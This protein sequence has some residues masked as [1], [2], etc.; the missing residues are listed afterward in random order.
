MDISGKTIVCGLIGDPVEHS[1][2]PA[3]QNAAFRK[4]GLDYAYVPFRVKSE[5]VGRAIAGMRALNI[6]GLN[7]TMPHKVAVIPFLDR[8]DDL[9]TKIG[10]V[11]TIAN[12]A[13][14]LTGYNTDASGFLQS[15]IENG[16][17]PKGKRVLV[18][19]AGG[20]ARAVTFALMDRQASLMI[21]NRTLD[22]AQ[23][24][25]RQLSL[26]FY[27]EVESGLLS[28]QTL[29]GAVGRAEMVVNTTSVGM[30]AMAGESPV[31]SQLLRPGLL[32]YDIV[33][34]P[35]RTRFLREAEAAGCMTISGT[36]MLAWQGAFAFERWTGKTAPVDL[37][38]AEIVGH[39]ERPE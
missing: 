19:G 35:V 37:M 9:A 27:G 22:R 29:A 33:Y 23:E 18:I 32:V 30:G 36:D 13:G 1:M 16:F 39:L 11:N 38:K 24:L 31:P 7:V 10:A 14:V 2:S 34:N 6:T 12:E 26:H 15:L 4:L 8:L 28:E 3:M 17:E 20:A 5:D 25:A 21:L